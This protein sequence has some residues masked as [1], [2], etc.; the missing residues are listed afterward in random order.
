MLQST[1]LQPLIPVKSFSDSTFIDQ[2][3]T[4]LL[5]LCASN[6]SG[7][8]LFPE[9]LGKCTI[10]EAKFPLQKQAKPVD[11]HPYRTN[12]R[13]QEVNCKYNESTESDGIPE[14]RP[15]AAWGSPVCIL[16]KAD[17]SP[18]FCIDDKNIIYIFLVR[19]TWPMPDIEFHID[20]VGGA[21]YITACDL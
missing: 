12:P 16:S 17:R 20:T 6:R 19:E 15:S 4:Q 1:W 18:R 21:K 8:L 7:F 5:D 10:T 14:E 11:H 3:Q 2:Q 9:K 13:A